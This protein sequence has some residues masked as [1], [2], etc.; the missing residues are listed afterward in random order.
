M[1]K[2][3]RRSVTR[4]KGTGTLVVSMKA[5]LTA[6]PIIV[7]PSAPSGCQYASSK[8][9]VR[10]TSDYW[11]LCST[12]SVALVTMGRSN[13]HMRL[14]LAR[15]AVV[16][17]GV[18][19]NC[20]LIFS[21]STQPSLPLFTR[22]TKCDTMNFSACAISHD[23][24]WCQCWHWTYI[25]RSGIVQNGHDPLVCVLLVTLRWWWWCLMSVM[26]AAGI[27]DFSKY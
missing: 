27:G 6:S 10:R 21:L 13:T 9:L 11:G 18:R 2:D 20:A 14:V 15:H 22:S 19:V 24:K 4:W 26:A 8:L 16:R 7:L 25:R 12:I 3:K 5:W 17:K 1:A 23:D